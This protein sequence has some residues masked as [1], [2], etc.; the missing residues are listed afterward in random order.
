LNNTSNFI[1]LGKFYRE[2][3]IRGGILGYV[4][5]PHSALISSLDTLYIRD[6]NNPD[7][8]A[9]MQR[10]PLATPPMPH[11]TMFLFKPSDVHTPLAAKRLRG[12][13]F[14]TPADRIPK[15]APGEFYWFEAIGATVEDDG[16]EPWGTLS[17]L[18]GTAANLLLVITAPEGR[19]ILYPACPETVL[20]FDRAHARLLIR[21]ISGLRDEDET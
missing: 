2:W 16:G 5:N 14:Y 21:K 20:S 10:L 1:E 19:E 8:L 3:G 6:P 15:P 9:E 18:E 11:Q 4:Y 7:V 13:R 17:R 12:Q